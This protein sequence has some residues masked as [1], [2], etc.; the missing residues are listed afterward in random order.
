V[1]PHLVNN[2]YLNHIHFN[3]QLYILL[4]ES[5]ILPDGGSPLTYELHNPY[6]GTTHFISDSPSSQ[7]SRSE[8]DLTEQAEVIDRQESCDDESSQHELKTEDFDEDGNEEMNFNEQ[9]IVPSENELSGPSEEINIPNENE[10]NQSSE[11]GVLEASKTIDT[12]RSFESAFLA[13]DEVKPD[14]GPTENKQGS[15]FDQLED[16]ELIDECSLSSISSSEDDYEEAVTTQEA[17]QQTDPD[18]IEASKFDGKYKILIGRPVS[19]LQ[20]MKEEECGKTIKGPSKDSTTA[21]S[22]E[23][24][25]VDDEISESE[26]TTV[27]PLQGDDGPSKDST[28]A[29]SIQIVEVAEEISESESTTI[30]PLQGDDG[31]SKDSTT[32]TSRQTIEVDDEISESELT[33]VEPLQG[34]DGPSKDS[35]TVTSRE[36]IE[37]DDEMTESESTTVEPLLGDDVPS[38]DSTTATSI[39]IVEVAEEIS[40]S[41]STT[42]EPLQG[43]DGPSKDSITASSRETITTILLPESYILPDGGSPL[44][45]ELHNPHDGT[46][47][48]ISDR[49]S[50]QT[51]RSE[52]DLTE[53]AE[54]MDTQ[55]SC[56]FFE[57]R[58]DFIVMFFICF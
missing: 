23:T 51:S 54:V 36:T 8:S 31:P 28:T 58:F 57:Y 1:H 45:Y 56:A 10:I 49:P 33:T 13:R 5:Y 26:L 40:E 20:G 11:Q 42:L 29:T 43:D 35:T 37:V 6:D 55:W 48:F 14:S 46:T 7:T 2:S 27:E 34:D 3:F 4:V 50:F 16:G 9:N 25:E 17:S 32:A 15:K 21:G 41:E 24:I 38:K 52:S 19:F 47:H 18:L 53:Q 22:R 30:E 44:T 39:Q 12:Q